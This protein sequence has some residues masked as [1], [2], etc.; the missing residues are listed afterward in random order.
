MLCAP[1]EEVPFPNVHTGAYELMPPWAEP[2]YMG[3][4]IK[5]DSLLID[6]S[7]LLS[8]LPPLSCGLQLCLQPE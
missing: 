7:S 8:L 1:E 3:L 6:A 4:Y 2:M 5:K